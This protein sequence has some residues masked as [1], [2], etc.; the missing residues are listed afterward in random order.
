M[1]G[2]ATVST[3]GKPWARQAQVVFRCS[4][5]LRFKRLTDTHN[6]Y[7]LMFLSSIRWAALRLELITNLMTLAVA[8]FVAFGI[9]SAPY[10]SKAMALSLV[11]QV[12]QA[13]LDS[14]G[15]ACGLWADS[16]GPWVFT[17]WLFGC[18]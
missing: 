4:F 2:E 15:S 10:S 1:L 9:S 12:R 8:L 7:L 5:F 18:L 16:G 3:L 17:P 6:N 14:W 13:L 11:L